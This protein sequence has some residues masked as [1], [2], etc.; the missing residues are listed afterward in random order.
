MS[1]LTTDV[2]ARMLLMAEFQKA[3]GHLN[4]MLELYFSSGDEFEALE[5]VVNEFR[6]KIMSTL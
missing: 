4:A 1:E 5:E 2:L 3:M 6:T